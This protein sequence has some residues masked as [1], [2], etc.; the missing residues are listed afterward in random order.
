M[1]KINKKITLFSLLTCGLLGASG[2]GSSSSN[3]DPNLL[4]QIFNYVSR[5][6]HFPS[7]K[8]FIASANP[9]IDEYKKYFRRQAI[10][11]ELND[12]SEIK[13][14][15]EY[16]NSIK[17]KFLIE[18]MDSVQFLQTND[19][20]IMPFKNPLGSIRRRKERTQYIQDHLLDILMALTSDNPIVDA[21]GLPTLDKIKDKETAI[22][23]ILDALTPEL[24]KCDKDIENRLLARLIDLTSDDPRVAALRLPTLD[25][26]K[27]K[28]TAINEILDIVHPNPGSRISHI[29]NQVYDYHENNMELIASIRRN[30]RNI[31]K[32]D[33]YFNLLYN[34][35][36]AQLKIESLRNLLLANRHNQ[37]YEQTAAMM[38]SA[39]TFK[40]SY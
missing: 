33:V 8:D 6:D 18:I 23:K 15:I 20:K 26:I 1:S 11:V 14:E 12:N 28:E 34:R 40:K 21:L 31:E 10:L 36:D 17:Q 29:I 22:N 2:G 13:S 5:E 4:G 7:A 16:I 25:K 24:D 38:Q 27:D 32:L 35:R 9:K 39:K 3:M 30:R 37:A 19:P